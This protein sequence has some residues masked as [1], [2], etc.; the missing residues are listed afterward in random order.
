VNE[1]AQLDAT[2]EQFLA[3]AEQPAVVDPAA[4]AANRER[5]IEAWLETVVR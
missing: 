2:F 1:K 5:W 3:V 4:I